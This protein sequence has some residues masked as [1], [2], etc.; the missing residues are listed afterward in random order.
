[1]SESFLHPESSLAIAAALLIVAVLCSLASSR[2]GVPALVLFLLLGMLA[3]S[4]GPGHVPFNDAYLAQLLGIAALSL[5]LFEGGLHTKWR[6]IKP[7]LYQGISLATLGVVIATLL[8]GAFASWLLHFDFRYG[9]LL[10]AIVSST[11]AAAVFNILNSSSS[12]LTGRLQALLELESAINDPMAACL[13]LGL[14]E[15]IQ[16]PE[17][18]A[19]SLFFLFVQQMSIGGLLG[20]LFGKASIWIIDRIKLD[21]EGLYA[22]L[23][24]GFIL[25]IYGTTAFL[26]G[27]GFLAVYMVG[28]MMGNANFTYKKSLIR[29]HESMA[30]L[31]QIVMFLALGLL[32]LPSRLPSVAGP[33]IFLALFLIFVARPVSV[34]VGLALTKLKFKEKLLISWVGLRGAV[35]IVL[36]TFPMLARLDHSTGFFDVVFF[37]VLTSV[38]LQGTLLESVAKWLG[39]AKPWIK[40]PRSPIEFVPTRKSK[41]EFVE[42]TVNTDS[43]MAGQTIA[44]LNLPVEFLIVLIDR[45]EEYIVPKGN[46]ELQAGDILMVLSN[47]EQLNQFCDLTGFCAPL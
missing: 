28:L 33:G 23:T 18:S 44:S 8:V 10:G 36:A 12:Q 35:P 13:T 2:F 43:A 31:M 30:W 40:K 26:H 16:H 45:D 4:D 24:V 20:W 6:S 46:M 5:I 38:L 9:L 19:W 3:G 47:R 7:V 15:W 1:M 42:I 25:L 27:S 32:A 14:V 11:D 34:F 22:V 17:L 41:N 29:F 39:V 37:I 21:S